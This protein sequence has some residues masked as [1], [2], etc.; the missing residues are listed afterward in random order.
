MNLRDAWHSG[1]LDGSSIEGM[2]PVLVLTPPNNRR[3]KLELE[4]IEKGFVQLDAVPRAEQAGSAEDRAQFKALI[5]SANSAHVKQAAIGQLK[6]SNKQR[7]LVAELNTDL[8]T[9]YTDLRNN[10]AVHRMTA[11]HP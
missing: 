6:D 8:R 7:A 9:I 1:K 11:S 5:H 3:I 4:V 2:N 10:L